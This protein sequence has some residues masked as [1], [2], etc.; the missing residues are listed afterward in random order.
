MT[1]QEELK[2]INSDIEL[3]EAELNSNAEEITQINPLTGLVRREAYL[4]LRNTRL[5]ENLKEL[6]VKKKSLIDYIDWE[7]RTS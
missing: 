3:L 5:E 1:A 6:R 7:R 2:K 4:R